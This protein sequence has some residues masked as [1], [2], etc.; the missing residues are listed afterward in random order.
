[1]LELL[2]SCILTAVL[3][4]GILIFYLRRTIPDIQ[5]IL[6]DVGAGISETF[7][8]TFKNPAVKNF[9]SGMGKKSGE[10][11]ADAALRNKVAEKALGSNVLLKKALDWLDITPIEGMQLLNDPTFG[12]VIRNAVAGFAKGGQGLLGG[13]GGGFGGGSGQGSGKVGYG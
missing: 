5:E 2:F 13:L 6:N 10:V 9:M 8:E 7:E 1:M 4:V 12:P 3:T 11:R